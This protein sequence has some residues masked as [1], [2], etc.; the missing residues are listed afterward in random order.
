[1]KK[2]IGNL[3]KKKEHMKININKK[4][5]KSSHTNNIRK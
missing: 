2:N 5:E 1:M 4:K 3:Q